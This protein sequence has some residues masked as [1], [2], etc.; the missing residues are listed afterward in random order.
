MSEPTHRISRRTFVKV[1]VPAVGGAAA[2]TL[3]SR[4]TLRQLYR[5]RLEPSLES[6]PPGPITPD[7]LQTLRAFTEALLDEA[8]TWSRYENFFRWRA[9]HLPGHRRLYER[10]ADELN[11]G[12]QQALGQPFV[13]CSRAQRIVLVRPV[14]EADLDDWD[15]AIA[16]ILHRDWLRFNRYVVER[17]R[18]SRL[19]RGLVGLRFN[20]Y[21]VEPLFTLFAYHDAWLR[22][23]Y[24]HPPGLPRGLEA[25]QQPPANA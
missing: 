21:V 18:S 23:G 20:R 3:I 5:T 10:L 2:L 17:S 19:A 25:Y 15:R 1:L 22:L 13:A 9:E 4:E 16:L 6:A 12:A 8:I 11:R 24:E 14:L 7:T